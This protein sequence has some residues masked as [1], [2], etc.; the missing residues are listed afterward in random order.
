M[1]AANAALHGA[2]DGPFLS[3]ASADVALGVIG[4]VAGQLAGGHYRP[5]MVVKIEG[6]TARASLRSIP[7]FNV[8]AALDAVAPLLERH[9]GHARA[10]GLTVRTERLPPLVERL[11][12]LAGVAL[13]LARPAPAL[14]VDAELL[15]GAVNDDLFRRLQALEPFGEANLSPL[16]LSRG[17]SIA[18]RRVVGER[19]L[20]LI[21]RT[22]RGSIEAMA[23][24]QG[25]RLA[26]VPERIDVVYGVRE[27]V[28]RGE[29]TI[30]LDVQDFGAAGVALAAAGDGAA[31][32]A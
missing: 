25:D 10:G 2:T 29:R 3:W 17:V 30:E 5:A 13:G 9:G 14:D 27:N 31:A 20:K 24:G 16:L 4:L 11:K 22:E 26:H 7:E 8:V 21:V 19:H 1:E 15:L 28:W 6:E 12:E 23:F 18:S 32:R